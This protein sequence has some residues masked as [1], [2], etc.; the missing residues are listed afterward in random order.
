LEIVRIKLKL[1][2]ACD[3]GKEV[4]GEHQSLVLVNV[5]VNQ[6]L[7]E[8]TYLYTPNKTKRIKISTQFN[9]NKTRIQSGLSLILE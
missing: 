9:Q 1:H 6:P 5:D 2:G 3:G 4:D 8:V 7:A